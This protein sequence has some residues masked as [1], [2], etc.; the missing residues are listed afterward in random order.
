LLIVGCA[1]ITFSNLQS[2]KMT[3]KGKFEF[4]PSFSTSINTNSFGLQT[5]Y[6]LNYKYNFRLRLERIMIERIMTDFDEFE[7]GSSNFIDMS[8]FNLKANI[9]HLSF[10]IKY[11]LLKNKSAIYIPISFTKI[12]NDSEIIKQIEP[13]Y[14]H[15]FSF[16]Y[17]EINPSIKAL[18]PLDSNTKDYLLAYK[19]I[20]LDSNTKDYLLA[21]NLGFGISS[22]LSKWVIRPEVGILT[23]P[24]REGSIPHMSI[25]LSLYQ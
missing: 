6:G 7:S 3:R 16:K 19:L 22:N 23:S 5:S 17:L 9:T 1:P 20:P 15:T 21:Y 25:G 2:A 24:L 4:T 18:I 12:D 10:G 13:T 14:I 11:K 8:I